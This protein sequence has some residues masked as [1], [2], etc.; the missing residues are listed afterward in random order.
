M[1]NK[2]TVVS[3]Q[4]EKTVHIFLVV[5]GNRIDTKIHAKKTEIRF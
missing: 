5:Y 4:T 1:Y 3:S 2:I